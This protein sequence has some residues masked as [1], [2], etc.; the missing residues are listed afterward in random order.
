MVRSG[1]STVFLV[2]K[3]EGNESS[4]V[5]IEVESFRL[6]SKAIPY[7]IDNKYEINISKSGR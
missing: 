1:V 5:K 4:G 6:E 3:S 7:C 2:S